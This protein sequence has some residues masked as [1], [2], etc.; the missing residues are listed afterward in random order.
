V[1]FS[2]VLHVPELGS[3]LLSVLYLARNHRFNVHISSERM[4]F[5]QDSVIR[6]CAPIDASNTTH[7]A[8]NVIPAPE[9]ALVSA[10]LTL[11]LDESLWH[12]RFAHHHHA[13]VKKLISQGVVLGLKLDST[14]PADPA[15]CLAG[16]PNA[17]PFP[18]S[19]SRAA[20]P[21]T[22]IHSDVHGPFPVRTHSG[23]RYWRA[24]IDDY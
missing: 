9:S 1:E 3:N 23:Y 24:W 14:A 11:P 21:L 4:D 13:G 7:L 18:P 22:L 19:T 15:P 8:G 2:R 5:V 20:R 12:R 16:K 6:F 10:T 17:A